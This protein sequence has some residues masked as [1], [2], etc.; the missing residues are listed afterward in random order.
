MDMLQLWN[1]E[2]NICFILDSAGDT[3]EQS[4]FFSLHMVIF[5]KCIWY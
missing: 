1:Y 2:T 3:E 5:F 4:V